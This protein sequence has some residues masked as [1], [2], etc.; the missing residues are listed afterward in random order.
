[1]PFNSADPDHP[2]LVSEL[3]PEERRMCAVQY[4]QLAGGIVSLDVRNR[5]LQLAAL[6]ETLAATES[7][8]DGA[9]RPMPD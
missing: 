4:R 8:G 7:S 1:M 9:A 3:T 5:L 6:H 2:S